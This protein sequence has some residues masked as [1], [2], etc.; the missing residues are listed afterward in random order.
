MSTAPVALAWLSF[1]V[2][3]AAFALPAVLPLSPTAGSC[4]AAALLLITLAVVVTT[5]YDYSL[6]T[7]LLIA[8]AAAL[9]T[10]LAYSLTDCSRCGDAVANANAVLLLACALMLVPHLQVPTRA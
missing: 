6:R 3:L 5:P 10:L 7:L 2:A 4:L 8:A 9:A 1:V